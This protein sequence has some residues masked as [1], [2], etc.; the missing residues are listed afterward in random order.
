MKIKTLAA[1]STGLAL[2]AL[3]LTNGTARAEPQGLDIGK[4]SLNLAFN[5]N[6][7]TAGML[8]IR[9]VIDDSDKGTLVAELLTNTATI[10][11]QDN[12]D[13]DYTATLTSC[14]ETPNSIVCKDN[15]SGKRVHAYVKRWRNYPEIW[16][17]SLRVKDLSE[18][19]TGTTSLSGPVTVTLTYGST[20]R[21][22][23]VAQA[24]GNEGDCKQKKGGARLRCRAR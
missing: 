3:L 13:F 8:K 6:P 23:V 1:I 5:P 17:L 12:G 15:A 22:D 18:Q 24:G 7:R 16:R 21:T 19:D 14:N 20:V 2:G 4:A 9:G 11:V 10:Q